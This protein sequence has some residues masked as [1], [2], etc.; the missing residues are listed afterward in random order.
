[1]KGLPQQGFPFALATTEVHPD[2]ARPHL[3]LNLLR[4]DPKAIR[5]AA[6]PGT[7]E[8]TPT[9]VSLFAPVR[10]P[11]HL[12]WQDNLFLVAA[13]APR[14]TMIASGVP[15]ATANPAAVRAAVGVG[16]LDGLLVWIEVPTSVA[17]DPPDAAL[18]ASLDRL[19]AKLGCSTRLALEGGVALLGGTTGLAGQNLSPPSSPFVRFVRG[20]TPSARLYF[21]STPVVSPAVWQPLQS[22]RVRYFPKPSKPAPSATV[23]PGGTASSNGAAP[24][25]LASP[26][27]SPSP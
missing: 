12:W 19:L 14:A 23:A 2:P 13:T 5:P 17:D 11:L 4:L 1:M 15:L 16:D 21:P 26:L 10:G 18:L 25:P 22:K 6:S 27:G 8:D 9:V 7:T 20:T 3:K 24:P